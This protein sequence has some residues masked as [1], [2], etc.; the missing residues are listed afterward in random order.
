M[1]L[2]MA[3][4]GHQNKS[5]PDGV[6]TMGGRSYHRIG[7]LLPSPGTDHNFAQIYLL[8]TLDASNRR[9]SIFGNRLDSV[10]L[11]AL[12]TQLRQ[13]NVLILQFCRAALSGVPELVWSSQS[14]ILNMQIGAMVCSTGSGRS[15]VVR[16]HIEEGPLQASDA[17]PRRKL[18]F[19]PDD[20]S[21]YHSLAYPLLFPIGN[22]GWYRGM[23]RVDR[24]STKV[25]NVSL[26]DY[27]RYLLM[28]RDVPSHLQR[29]E[30]LGLEF[31]CDAWAQ[32]EARAAAF[33]MRPEQQSKYRCG[34]KCAVEDQLSNSGNVNDVSTPMIL[35]SSFVGSTKWYYMLYL[36]AMALPQRL[37][38]PDLFI[39]FTCNP[40]WEEL[41]KAIP[42]HS[43]WRFHPDIVARVFWLKFKSLMADIIEDEI[44]GAVAGYVWRIEWQLRGLPHVHL[45]IILVKPLRSPSDIDAIISAEIPDP[46][47]FPVLH[48]LVADLMIHTPCDCNVDAGCRQHN[49]KKTCKRHFPKCMSPVTLIESN[50]FP[51]YR[52]RGLFTCTSQGRTVSDD[53]VVSY[54]PFLLLRYGAHLNI[55]VASS[56]LSFKYV[57]KYVLKAPDHAAVSINEIS[58][59]L[60]G[61]LLSC[62]EAAWRFLG[63]PLHKEFPPVTRLQLHLPNEHSIVFDPT[64]DDDDL[65]SSIVTSTSTLLEWFAL[66]VRDSHARS[67]LY[68]HIPEQY[69]WH[70]ANKQWSRRTCGSPGIGRMLAVSCKNLE[71]FSLRRLLGVVKGATGWLD[72]YTVDGFTYPTFHDACGARGMLQDDADVICAL[73]LIFATCC[74]LPT[75]RR[76][77]AMVL[78]NRTVQNAVGLFE[79]FA[80]NLCDDGDVSPINCTAALHEIEMIMMQHGRSLTDTDFG[81][82]LR[83]RDILENRA[84]L[85]LLRRHSFA[86]DYCVERRDEIVNQFTSEQQHAMSVITASI[87]NPTG[88][89]VYCVLAAAGCG[90]SFFV[91]GLTWHLRAENKIVLNVAAS[92]LA[93]TLLLS[94]ATA[95]STFKIPIPT[96][97]TSYCGLKTADR[98]LI[99]RCSLICYDEMSMVSP[100]IANMLDRSLR[101]I[102]GIDSPF[103]GKCVVFLG[104]FKQLLP[105]TPGRQR[106][107]TIQNATWWHQCQVLRFTVNFRAIK[108]PSFSK[109]LEDVG[110]G[111]IPTVIVPEASRVPD[112]SSLIHRVY[113]DDLL[114]SSAGLNMILAPDL[115]SCDRINKLCLAAVPGEALDASAHD[116]DKDNCNPNVYTSDYISSLKLSGVPPAVLSLKKGARYMVIRNYDVAGGIC[117]GTLCCVTDV[118]RQLIFVRLLT[119]TQKGKVV[120][121]P[122]CSV[123]VSS[124]N[125]G[126][127]FDF[128][129]VQFPLVPAYCVS[130][131]KSQGQTLQKVG[132]CME[133]PVFAHGQLYTA[134]SRTSG[135][136]NLFVFAPGDCLINVVQQHVLME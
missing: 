81:F 17:E 121:L 103:G 96:T 130:I 54:S 48:G 1:A 58:A 87:S 4:V 53:W 108:N 36:D 132:L 57:Y 126:L 114:A 113:G 25:V 46:D 23:S 24:V 105:V 109:F 27:G 116:D 52:R 134:L 69:S 19:I 119:G 68:Q 16:R 129:R 43:H 50:K 2:A 14:D 33:H 83:D 135:W 92:A 120:P 111:R 55:E 29:C 60:D 94:G 32:S 37:H 41:K 85:S 67:L 123:P 95:H 66:N 15:I 106:T 59:H 79:M 38:A 98:E 97:D 20:H 13:Y 64:A 133:Y 7:S 9:S 100:E 30:R 125:S 107:A 39:T 84:A 131:H 75:M 80:S 136:E 65:T 93:A 47:A 42:A 99:R 12:D 45:L 122:R 112:M 6:F 10:V 117:N 102:M 44:F 74:H 72:L 73:N 86:V 8:D 51:T 70:T 71:L 127:P 22:Q 82:T 5:L 63:L 3:S 34:R 101:D 104:D 21:L 115:D 89:N 26:Q 78:L 31:M 124:D 128:V 11:A 62:S 110:C 77:F 35:P 28:H 91:N 118:H 56:L 61:R 49:A 88:S 90:K 76:E 40:Q 18:E